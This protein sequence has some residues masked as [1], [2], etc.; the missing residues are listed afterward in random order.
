MKYKVG[1]KV[2]VRKDLVVGKEYGDNVFIADMKKYSGKIM[3][4]G[5]I[6]VTGD[7]T[8]KE[9]ANIWYWSD[10]MLEDR[11][12]IEIIVDGNKTI[13]KK[14]GKV[15]IA[16]CSPEDKFDIFTGAKLAIDRLEKKCTPYGWLKEGVTYCY[17]CVGSDDLYDYY[18]YNNDEVD[19][20]YI[21]RGLVFKTKEE[22][23]EC[24]KKMLE[25]VK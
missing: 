3:T 7:Y 18:T 11:D 23:I 6:T 12:K 9:D 5:G 17:P 24:A 2:R 25:V 4:V 14:D 19:R 16:K 15:G 1:D 8:F 21:S 20:K 22:A 13:A 10:E